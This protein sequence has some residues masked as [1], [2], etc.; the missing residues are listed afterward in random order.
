VTP[1]SGARLGPLLL[2][3]L[4]FCAV[5][6][7]VERSSAFLDARVSVRWG[8]TAI[9]AVSAAPGAE[10]ARGWPVLSLVVARDDL[11]DPARGLLANVLEHGEAWE[12]PGTVAYFEDGRLR[13]AS[14]VGVRVHGG[15]SRDHSERQGFRLYFRRRYGARQIPPG[16]LF[17]PDAQPIRT[18]VVHNDLR[19]DGNGDRWRLV[20]PVAYD[21]AEAIGAV[22]PDTRPA[23]FFL[24][25]ELQG[26]FVL[27]ERVSEEF[28]AAHW[29]H[30]QVRADQSE[31]NRLWEWVGAR[32]PLTMDEVSQRIDLDNLTRWFLSVAFCATRDA[33]QGPSQFRNL[34]RSEAEWFWVNWDM[35]RSFRVWDADSYAFLLEQVGGPRRGRNPAEPRAVVMTR[36]L[37]D[38]PRFRE[39]FA[40]LFDRVMNHRLTSAFLRERVNHYRQIA[41]TLSPDDA[42][43]LPRLEQF[44][45]RRPAF[46]RTLTEEWLNAG[47]SQPLRVTTP[48]A[49]AIDGEIVRGRFEGVY[50]PGREI[51]F[52][53]LDGRSRFVEWRVNGA[54]AGRAPVLRLRLQAPTDVAAIFEG[55]AAPVAM[56]P[57]APPDPATREWA[58]QPLRW[59]R[60]P[61]G[62][63]KAG[64]IPG[65]PDCDGDEPPQHDAAIATPFQ[66]LATEVTVGQFAAFARQS[67][68]A[69]PRLPGW[70][71]RAEQPM[72][73]L[74]WDDADAFCR[75]AGG[76]LPSELEWEYA[77]RGG[78]EGWLFPWPGGFD[79][80]ANL[81][82][83]K[84][85]DRFPSTAPAGSFQP[86]RF[87]LFD[88]IGNVWEWTAD[89][90]DPRAP[91]DA[92]DLRA[93]RGGSFMTL[94]RGA[95]IS[96]RAAL[97][98]LG[99]HNLEVGFR[100]VR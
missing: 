1:A 27:T 6:W 29:G 32:R 88:M 74:T 45:D 42:A 40:R 57:A 75:A 80:Q 53:V 2:L 58:A 51:E 10:I 73:N 3:T 43:F 21:I 90:Y 76:R 92:F 30:A 36:L 9:R 98:R 96:A 49:I 59:V 55:A 87:G 20:N 70:V 31:F 52:S 61:P 46:F 100:C 15:G 93:A 62:R 85:A 19:V 16:I 37:L 12:R 47:P 95:R 67:D 54:A 28:F 86:N 91:A 35:D 77:A 60:L 24:N 48:A 84:G 7:A 39:Y 66:M 14:D 26:L 25:G 18:L 11:V 72:V 56:P 38:D 83:D 97:S 41:L 13:F 78:V 79:G 44:L 69:M 65:D 63:F 34:T 99:R 22:A 82:D 71:T 81:G 64:C 5:L 17:E 94:P 68:R 8:P 33:Y 4:A 23:R 50:L 89:R